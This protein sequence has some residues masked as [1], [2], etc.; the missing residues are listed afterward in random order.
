VFAVFLGASVLVGQ[1]SPAALELGKTISGQFTPGQTDHYSVAVKAGQFFRVTISR[2][3]FSTVVRLAEP[4]EKA[5]VVELHWPG[6]LHRREPLCWIAKAGGEYRIEFGAAGQVA[7]DNNYEITLEE[8]RV[9]V[10]ADP[11]QLAVQQLFEAARV[12]DGKREYP[13]AVEAWD[14]ALAAVK[15]WNAL[16]I[17]G[18]RERESA[19]LYSL[20]LA[21]TNSK[22]HEKAIGYYEQALAIRRSMKDR[23]GEGDTLNNLGSTYRVLDQNEK[24]IGYWEQALAI[25]TEI[26]DRGGRE[27][28]LNNLGI[29]YYALH[30]YQKAISYHEQALAIARELHNRSREAFAL[31]SIGFAYVP[32]SEFAKSIGYY[33]QVLAIRRELK[34]RVEEANLLNDLAYAHFCLSHQEIAIDYYARAL[35]IAREA[36]DRVLEA[37]ALNGLGN[38][39]TQTSLYEKAIASYE[40]SLAISRDL[41]DRSNEAVAISNLGELY[42]SIGQYEKA[43]GYHQQSLAITRDGNDRISEAFD[44]GYLGL[45]YR[46]LGDYEKALGYYQQSLAIA[47]SF[48]ILIGQGIL[49][50]EIGCTYNSMGQFDKAIDYFGRSLQIEREVKNRAVEGWALGNLGIASLHLNQPEKAIAYYEQA[51]AIAREVKDRSAEGEMISNLGLAYE[52]L[53]QVD[54]AIGLEQQA[55]TIAREVKN[56]P[57][58]HDALYALMVSYQAAKKPRLASFYGKQ[59]VNVIQSMRR[60]NSGLSRDSRSRFLESRMQ[61]YHKLAEILIAQNRLA[62]AEQVLGLLKEEEYFQY[63]RRDATEASSLNRVADFTSDEADWEKRYRLIAD[64]LMEIGVQRGELLATAKNAP[65]K[66]DEKQRLDQ[67]D[68]DIRSGNLKFQQFLGDLSRHFDAKVD[69]GRIEELRE[70]QGIMADLQELPAGTVAIYTLVTDDKFHAILRS[71]QAQ[72][73]F[74]YAIARGELNRMVLDFR[75]VVRDPKLDPRPLGQ[76]LYKILIAGMARDLRQAGAKTLM[77]SLDG[78]LRYVPLA[79]LYDGKQYLMEQYRMSVMTLASN[80]RLK[81]QPDK[82]WRAAGFGVTKPYEGAPALP[83]VSRELAGIIA[84]KAGDGG[85]LRGEIRLDGDFTLQ[86]MRQTL[87]LERFPV[88][89]IASHFRFQP[90]NDTNSFLLLG[91]GGHFSLAELKTS[92]NL[93][94]GVQLLTLSACNTGVGDGTEVEGFG[95]LAQR[96]GAKAVIASLWPV[97]DEST[98]LLMQEFYRIRESAPE[99][100]KLEAL[101]QAQLSLLRGVVGGEGVGGDRG[102]V[103]EDELPARVEAPKFV[104][105][106]KA[107]FGHPYYWAPFFLMGN[108]L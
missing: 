102:L 13:K 76:E 83:S 91:D 48:G 74:E 45:A 99:A 89:H 30:Q 38:L 22:Q 62:E 78:T 44:L 55:L 7:A 9:A 98:S 17:Y 105:D 8:L 47:E 36:K 31:H 16:W 23:A 87:E 101:R 24:A 11:K 27:I 82:V 61:S 3:G 90:G 2:P 54:K 67:Y 96:Q 64:R 63:L 59:A 34:D 26:N 73:H 81:D 60:G 37:R 106:P 39:Y 97:A 25:R 12:L 72:K 100:T 108:W 103:H 70:S 69:T 107:R 35:S 53:R 85:V 21:C 15:E 18:N 57:N 79:A 65:L 49:L 80:A 71:A 66:D 28:A 19:A 46:L 104:A 43:I 75:E 84:T 52:S 6:A 86:T 93:F 92:A 20:A 51:L 58:E 40:Q 50:N 42:T 95:T 77:W 29:G 41:K 88:V 14:R 56:R 94:G 10:P 32:L 5:N 1:S 68:S 4:G 33:E